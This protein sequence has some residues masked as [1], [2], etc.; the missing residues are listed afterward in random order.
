MV[1]IIFPLVAALFFSL[2]NFTENAVVDNWCKRLKPQCL[3]VIYLALNV[4]VMLALF[5]IFGTGL[6]DNAGLIGI[7]ILLGAGILH[8]SG[9]IPYLTALKKA[10]TTS[11]TL[12][13]QMNPILTLILG[14][15][16]L[17]QIPTWNQGLAFALIVIGML[18]VVV[19]TGRKI[20]KIDFKTALPM[21]IAC[22]FWATSG[23]VFVMGV[24]D[25]DFW[26]AFFWFNVGKFII[27][28]IMVIVFKSW[29]ADFR[30]FIK[31]EK[32]KKIFGTVAVFAFW[33]IGEMMW[34]MGILIVPIA[35]QSVTTSVLQLILTF[36]L[37][38]ILTLLWPKFGREKLQKKVIVRHAIATVIIVVGI[39]LIG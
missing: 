12:L 11:I 28:A 8:S 20:I 29:R 18:L 38:I 3:K 37:G 27:N 6:W 32:W 34:R 2:C 26:T 9:G 30:R 39:I 16:F 21:F 33:F 17:A 36:I 14:I 7:L 22:L 15:I 1:W 24:G 4:V 5:L 19:E 23:V 10:D 13:G 25:M 31:K 35:I